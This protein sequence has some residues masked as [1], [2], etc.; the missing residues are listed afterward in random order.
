MATL[1]AAPDALLDELQPL[2]VGE[3][4]TR[5]LAELSVS[6]VFGVPGDYSLGLCDMIIH[7]GIRWVGTCNELNAGYAADAYARL[8]GLGVCCVTYGVGGFSALNACAGAYAESVPLVVLSGAPSSADYTARPGARALPHHALSRDLF[9]Q[10]KAY[11]AVAAASVVLLD[12]DLAATQID[13]ALRTCLRTSKPVLLELPMDVAQARPTSGAHAGAT[14]HAGLAQRLRDEP[15]SSWNI[16]APHNPHAC[17]AAVSRVCGALALAARPALLAGVEVHRRDCGPSVARLARL[18]RLPVATT[19]H[20]KTALEEGGAVCAG[21]YSGA[22]SAPAVRAYV[23]GSDLLLILGAAWTDMDYVTASLP[24]SAT[25][26]TVVDGS[27]TLRAPAPPRARGGG[28]GGGGG[29]AHVEEFGPVGLAT[30]IDGLCLT[31]LDALSLSAV[32]GEHAGQ[33][34]PPPPPD[35]A[36][37]GASPIPAVEIKVHAGTSSSKEWEGA[38]RAAAAAA[39]AVRDLSLI[40]I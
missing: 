9:A 2:S 27:V 24:D 38:T 12:A 28:G 39:T 35:A 23:E 16:G 20:G 11:D 19:R 40:H 21:V 13:D 5:R 30:L 18:L 7:A 26:V 8:N 14:A 4:L 36:G 31:T 25:V 17:A 33:Q 29:G 22:M 1:A 32:G 6:C 15:A 37:T 34:T 10:R 3:Y